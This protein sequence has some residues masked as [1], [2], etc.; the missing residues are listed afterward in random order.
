MTQV[1]RQARV[2]DLLKDLNGLEPLKK[3]L[4]SELNYDRVNRPLSRRTWNKTAANALAE[5]PSSSPVAGRT[6]ISMWYTADSR[7]IS[8]SLGRSVRW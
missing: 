3:L 2:Q 7:R 4:W 5:D 6:M 1:D 8:S